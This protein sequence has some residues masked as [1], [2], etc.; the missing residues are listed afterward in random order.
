MTTKDKDKNSELVKVFS[1]ILG[2]HKVRVKFFVCFISALCKVQT[3][4]FSRLAE[5]FAGKA[6]VES[7]LRRIQR[8]FAEFIV[9]GDLIARLIYNLLPSKPPYRLC[10]DRTN[11]KF[12]SVDINILM[13]SIAWQGIAIP[14][15]WSM[16]PKRGNSNHEE[17]RQLLQRY[18]NL[19]GA[20]SI[21]S[22]MADREFIGREWFEDLILKQTPFYIR[23]RENMWI[24]VPHKGKVRAFW[25]FN[26]L[27]RNKALF[28][29]K[30]VC[31]DGNWVYLSGMKVLN[32]ENKIEF[33]IIATFSPDSNALVRYKDRWQIETMFKAF[34]SSGFNI[35][36]THLINLDR[37]SKMVSLISV[38][39]IWAYRVGIYRNDH[40]KPIQI[41]K[42]GRR[43]YS[44]F[45]YG[46]IFIANALL[47][48]ADIR[49]FEI[50]TK[51]LSCT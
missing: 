10:L 7:N 15:I 11:W 9:D 37:I 12:G 41:K 49:N 51:V 17:R 38:A 28:H 25:L 8:F 20:D 19:F 2:W 46:L 43:A 29:P 33:V 4:C 5:G 3:V 16:L 40:I 50:C 48:P 31:I 34:K 27:P 14:L 42:H 21:E 23:I 32:K 39:F 36:D 22:L 1:E 24:D 13:I 45:K 30:I 35:E 26:S 44:F 47:N 6:K 18:I